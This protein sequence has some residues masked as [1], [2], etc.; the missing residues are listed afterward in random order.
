MKRI[1]LACSSGMST[2]L[3][4]TKMQEYAKSVGEEAEIWAVG[5]DQAKKEM[6]KA[7][8]VLIG[9]QMSFLKGELQKEAQK[10][11][12]PVDVI[13]MVAYG[14]ADGKKVYEQALKLMGDK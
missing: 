3:L 1:L 9:P 10:Y 14:M 2:S 12:I 11:G 6:A 8:V 4:V 5:Q 7:D 13:D